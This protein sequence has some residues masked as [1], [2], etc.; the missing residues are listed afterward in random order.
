MIDAQLIRTCKCETS[1]FMQVHF[2]VKH[3]LTWS[4]YIHTFC[5]S[6]SQSVD[7]ILDEEEQYADQLKEYLAF[8]DSLRLGLD[9][10]FNY[11]VMCQFSKP[12]SPK[13]GD[14]NIFRR[15]FLKSAEY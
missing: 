12:F 10:D 5:C 3:E 6:F 2:T 14:G 13:S 8:A 7:G 4:L 15:E 1:I 11:W 9:A